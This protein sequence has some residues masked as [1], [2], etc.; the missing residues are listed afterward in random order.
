MR[1]VIAEFEA[2][3]RE[4]PTQWFQFTPFWSDDAASAAVTASGEDQAVEEL[5]ARWQ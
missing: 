4:Y 2:V 1:D 5:R 3:V